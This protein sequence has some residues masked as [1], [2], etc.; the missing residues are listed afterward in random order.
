MS[1][2]HNEGQYPLLSCNIDSVESRF[3]FMVDAFLFIVLLLKVGR[4]GVVT[5]E[6]GKSIENS[7]VIVEGMQFNRS[8]L[9]PYF[10]TDRRKVTVDLHNCKA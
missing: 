6:K 3:H 4:K 1:L 2:W 8:Y 7:L 10:I 9:S 5:S